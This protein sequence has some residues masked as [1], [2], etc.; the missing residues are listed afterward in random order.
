MDAPPP[1]KTAR[2]YI[3]GAYSELA[4]VT[5]DL[6]RHAGFYERLAAARVA[7]TTRRTTAREELRAHIPGD[8]EDAHAL[9]DRMAEGDR[10]DDAQTGDLETNG[11]EALT[12][13]QRSADRLKD[14]MDKA[15]WAIDAESRA[16]DNAVV[17]M[18]RLEAD[19]EEAQTELRAK[20]EELR[21]EKLLHFEETAKRQR[22]Q[23]LHLQTVQR[24]DS[25][26]AVCLLLSKD[27]G[28][29]K[30]EGGDRE[31]SADSN[32]STPGGDS[33]PE[34]DFEIDN[35]IK[36]LKERAEVQ[37]RERQQHLSDIAQLRR[38]L[39]A[40]NR[41]AGAA[42][43][44]A[45]EAEKKLR[46]REDMHTKAQVQIAT[47]SQELK[48]LHNKHAEEL[49]RA[50]RYRQE[51]LSKLRS[52]LTVADKTRAQA[53]LKQK[54]MDASRTYDRLWNILASRTLSFDS[55]PWPM[56]DVPRT[57]EDITLG[58]VREFMF[59]ESRLQGKLRRAVLKKALLVWHPDKFNAVLQRVQ[60][61]DRDDVEQAVNLIAGYLNDL[62]CGI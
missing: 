22:E 48:E 60:E 23:E 18:K 13:C 25:F 4:W 7:H 17:R 47:L 57:P 10:D 30:P 46:L 53:V 55:I 29:L 45:E 15:W 1:S 42:V 37:G 59:S 12:S 34:A 52:A 39:E 9:L 14:S 51:D 19:L 56:V 43:R 35:L 32:G 3:S 36:S 62:N 16:E 27:L 40:A 44:R 31:P 24:L 58:A 20:A 49:Q 54:Q 50:R 6:S 61:S 11:G 26:E 38:D 5:Y 21:L 2:D 28:R 33:A 8:A 41:S